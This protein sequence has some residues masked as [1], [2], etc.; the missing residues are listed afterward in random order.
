MEKT[1]TWWKENF[2]EISLPLCLVPFQSFITLMYFK[3]QSYDVNVRLSQN[4]NTSHGLT[5]FNNLIW[6]NLKMCSYLELPKRFMF[7]SHNPY[8][9]H[10]LKFKWPGK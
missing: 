2:I 10:F 6:T 7:I 8:I 4:I 3:H 5:C 1:A 9:I